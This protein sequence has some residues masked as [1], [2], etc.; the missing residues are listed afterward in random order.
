MPLIRNV[1]AAIDLLDWKYPKRLPRIRFLSGDLGMD[2][3][4]VREKLH[5]AG[6]ATVGIPNSIEPI[7]K[8]PSPEMIE[9]VLHTPLLGEKQHTTQIKTACAYKVGL[10]L[11]GSSPIVPTQVS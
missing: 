8:V 5:R 3:P 2:D 4:N 11:K 1:D 10:S 9:E 7:P 6:I